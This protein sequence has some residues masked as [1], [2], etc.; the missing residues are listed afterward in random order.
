MSAAICVAVVGPGDSASARD[1]ADAR[2]VGALCA[3]RG[4]ITLTGGRNAGVMAAAA[5]G[6]SSAGGISIGVLPGADRSD[7]SPSLTA[8]LP[9]GLGEARNAV[10]V[11][12]AD[13]VIACGMSPGTLSEIA[14]AVKAKRPIA[15][16]RPDGALPAGLGGGEVFT[17]D[18][19]AAAVE[20]MERQ[21]GKGRA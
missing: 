13:G 15:L 11:T 3:A 21:I 18:S 1:V 7:A 2:S 6:A 16:V 20:W 14:L 19:A 10:L 17:A 12:A 9:T 8:S 5:E 4:W